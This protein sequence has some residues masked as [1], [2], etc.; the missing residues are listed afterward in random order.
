[1][2]P[3]RAVEEKWQRR[4]ETR[5]KTSKKKEKPFYVLEMFPYP[6]GQLHMGHVRNY[7]LGDAIARFYKHLGYDVLHPMGWDAFGLPAEN[8]AKERGTHPG[9]WTYENISRMRETFK[10]LGFDLQWDKELATCHPG[11]YGMGQKLFIA[12]YKKGLVVQKESWVNWDPV[13]QSVLA[14]EQVVD[15]CGWRSG[16]PVERK[17]LTQWFMKITDYA[18]DLLKDLDTLKGWPERVV[19]MQEN[20]IGK[21]KG[22]DISFKLDNSSHESITVYTTRPETLYGASFIGIAA[23]HPLAETWASKDPLLK[24]FLDECAKTPTSEE[25]LATQEKK[26]YFTGYYVEHPLDSSWKIPVYVANFVLMD[27]GTGAVFACPGHDERD[28]AFAKKYHLPIQTVVSKDNTMVH[29]DFLNHMS[30]EEAKE[31]MIKK[32]EAIGAGESK[33]QYRLRDW[34][35]SRQRYWGCP[36]P[37]IHC[38]SCGAVPIP[39]DQFPLELPKDVRFDQG[40]NPLEHHPIWKHTSC[41]TCGGKAQRE[42]DTLDTFFESSWYFMRFP[43]PRHPTPIDTATVNHYG[44]V[45]WY[46]GGIEHAVM[47]LLYARFFTKALKDMGYVSYTEPFENLLTQGMVNHP[48]YRDTLTK[49]WLYPHEIT[50]DQEGNCLSKSGNPVEIGRGIKMSKS[51]KN[52][53]TP[54]QIID[55]YGADAARLFILSD[56]PPEKDFEWSTES[57]EGAW[58]YVNRLWRLKDVVLTYK[59]NGDAD[60][61]EH[62]TKIFHRYNDKIQKAYKD[63]GFNRVIAFTR[64]LSNH[65]EEALREE[66]ASKEIIKSLY[67][68][69]LLSLHPLIPHVTEEIDDHMVGA[70]PLCDVPWPQV[71]P[72]FLHDDTDT[73]AVQVN[74]K[75]R[76]QLHVAKTLSQ[77]AIKEKALAL[78]TVQKALSGREIKKIIVVPGRIVNIVGV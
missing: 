64:E 54:L 2:Y 70:V 42:T 34:C 32:L 39:E 46:I 10:R 44:P 35:I 43:S 65:L 37:I 36:I 11:Y 63:N 49:E 41:P 17:K 30:V 51:K 7:A 28:E 38:D 60:A 72:A 76:G 26:G 47:H 48:S 23:A 12:L 68:F 56:T 24:S 67:H 1:M 31:A 15:G 50:H 25:A 69:L 59:G 57:L 75:L 4:W 61:T 16:V 21:S 27:Y 8:A 13:E 52:V 5:T 55:N 71:D 45:N 74:G 78:D 22:C 77:E 33:T 62:L 58:R 6:S 3:F 66:R 73:L 40:G 9:E 14:N 53:V 19:K 18:E 29:S 20:W